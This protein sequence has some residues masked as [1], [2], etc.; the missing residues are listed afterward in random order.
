MRH[1][2]AVTLMLCL[3][4]MGFASTIKPFETIHVPDGVVLSEPTPMERFMERIAQ[5]ETPGG[6][7]QTVNKFGMMGKYQ[8]SYATMRAVGIDVSR[9]EFLESKELQDTAMVR[10]M[11][12]N[13][14][15][16]HDVIRRFEG[17]TV[18]GVKITRASIIAGAHFAGPNGVRRYLT[19]D[20]ELGTIDGMGTSLKQYMRYFVD[21]H[22][23]PLNT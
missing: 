14:K 9:K 5:I 19:N 20:D 16:L 15:E 10:L 22:L 3:A 4:V 6:G 13:E 11:M 21:F 23:P 2:V 7:Y 1:S 17:R 18:K 8:F 12:R